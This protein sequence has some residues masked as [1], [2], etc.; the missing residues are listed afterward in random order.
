MDP[1]ASTGGTDRT[2]WGRGEPEGLATGADGGGL[3]ALVCSVT[4]R[5]SEPPLGSACYYPG[6]NSLRLFP[7][8]A[9]PRSPPTPGLNHR[10]PYPDWRSLPLGPPLVGPDPLASSRRLHRAPPTSVPR[11]PYPLGTIQRPPRCDVANTKPPGPPLHFPSTSPVRAAAR[12]SW[13]R[14]WRLRCHGV[15]TSHRR[16][17]IPLVES[18]P[19]PSEHSGTSASRAS[20][21]TFR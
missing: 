1:R 13:C 5:A 11:Y 19:R 4:F 6:L 9:P 3:G 17:A 14:W 12:E 15:R 7:H 8:Q 18:T 20:V 16:L 2:G 10:L 21:A